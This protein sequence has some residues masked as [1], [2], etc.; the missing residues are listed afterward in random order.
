MIYFVNGLIIIER[1]H[2]DRK[3]IFYSKIDKEKL[4]G[5]PLEWFFERFLDFRWQLNWTEEEILQ[6]I[7]GIIRSEYEKDPKAWN[8]RDWIK[9]MRGW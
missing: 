5:A 2:N 9:I 7:Y 8:K 1:Y 6:E 4:Y 3:E